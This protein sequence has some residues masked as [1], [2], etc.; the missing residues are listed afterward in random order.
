MQRARARDAGRQLAEE[1][2]R[3]FLHLLQFLKELSI[4]RE[5]RHARTLAKRGAGRSRGPPENRVTG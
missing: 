2:P 3:V 1:Q 4:T 5:R